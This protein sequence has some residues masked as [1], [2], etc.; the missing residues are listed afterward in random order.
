MGVKPRGELRNDLSPRLRFR[1][2][3]RAR[4]NVIVKE[5][6]VVHPLCL[7]MWMWI[8]RT[9]RQRLRLRVH[10]S[11]DFGLALSRGSRLSAL[12]NRSPGATKLVSCL[13]SCW[14][15]C[16]FAMST[17]RS[18][19]SDSSSADGAEEGDDGDWDELQDDEMEEVCS[20]S[21]PR[22]FSSPCS[23][24]RDA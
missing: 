23:T 24:T 6:R 15:V 4:K 22:V 8:K 14:A 3:T 9:I 13:K 17:K 21:P 2:G 12:A 5:L 19:E 7:S 20:L 10:P 1:I 18:A 16:R 11:C